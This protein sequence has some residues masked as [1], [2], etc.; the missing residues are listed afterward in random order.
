MTPGVSVE[1]G[2]NR[3]TSENVKEKENAGFTENTRKY[4]FRVSSSQYIKL[5]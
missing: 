5:K 3:R 4:M 1:F 2:E